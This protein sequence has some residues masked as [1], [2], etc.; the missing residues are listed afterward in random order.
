MARELRFHADL[1]AA[2]AGLLIPENPGAACLQPEA[3]G[4]SSRCTQPSG[5]GLSRPPPFFTLLKLHHIRKRNQMLLFS[6]ALIA[7]EIFRSG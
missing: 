2:R 1:V 4:A 3:S 5:I 6:A 7:V